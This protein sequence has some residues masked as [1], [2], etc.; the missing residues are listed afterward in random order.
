M[1]KKNVD[2]VLPCARV[3][4]NAGWKGTMERFGLKMKKWVNSLIKM[5][6]E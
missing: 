1:E 2:F 4:G 5:Q 6:R 3:K